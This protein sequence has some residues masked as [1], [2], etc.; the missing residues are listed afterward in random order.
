MTELQ[1]LMRQ[2]NEIEN[3]IRTGSNNNR[4]TPIGELRTMLLWKSLI[5]M[6]EQRKRTG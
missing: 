4:H 3:K 6:L 2:R 5:L 1:E